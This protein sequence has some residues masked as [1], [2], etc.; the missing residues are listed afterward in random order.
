MKRAVKEFLYT[1]GA[2]ALIVIGIYNICTATPTTP[3][4]YTQATQAET[5]QTTAAE[6]KIEARETQPVHE[7]TWKAGTEYVWEDLGNGKGRLRVV[8]VVKCQCG[9]MQYAN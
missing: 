5:V 8:D 1:V 3:E 4:T 2:V 6:E 9:E 7:H